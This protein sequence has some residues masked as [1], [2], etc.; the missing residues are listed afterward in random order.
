M[1]IESINASNKLNKPMNIFNGSQYCWR[2][3]EGNLIVEDPGSE[4]LMR[5]N[6]ISVI[7]CKIKFILNIKQ[8]SNLRLHH[9]INVYQ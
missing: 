7:I 4:D 3:V 9:F 5:A 2:E 1:S 6:Y 8:Y